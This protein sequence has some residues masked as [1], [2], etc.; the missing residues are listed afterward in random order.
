MIFNR[1]V[2]N[3][4]GLTLFYNNFLAVQDVDSL[5]KTFNAVGIG[6]N[7]ATIEAVNVAVM[8]LG[9]GG[10]VVDSCCIVVVGVVVD[11]IV[12]TTLFG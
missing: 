3:Q 1:S 9:I 5:C 10:Y 12:C 6:A 4:N 2:S 8:L 7:K 11:E